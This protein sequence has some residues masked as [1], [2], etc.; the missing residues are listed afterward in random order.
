MKEKKDKN[1]GIQILPLFH[2]FKEYF[3][4]LVILGD[5]I[6]FLMAI[7]SGIQKLTYSEH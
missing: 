6:V 1:T 2:Q 5:L 3:I 7:G 4:I